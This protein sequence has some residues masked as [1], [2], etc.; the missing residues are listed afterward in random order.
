MK[1]EEYFD[2][3]SKVEI[4]FNGD[5]L[6]LIDYYDKINKICVLNND[7][8]TPIK[9][10]LFYNDVKAGEMEGYLL[11]INYLDEFESLID[12]KEDIYWIL[13]DLWDDL[14]TFFINIYENEYS[15]TKKYFLIEKIKSTVEFKDEGVESFLLNT[16]GLFSEKFLG[17]KIDY[18]ALIYDRA[19]FI[20]N[21]EKYK[22]GVSEGLKYSLLKI[23]KNLNNSRKEVKKEYIRVLAKTYDFLPINTNNKKINIWIKDYEY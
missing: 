12:Y 17:I 13:E 23:I 8:V 9:M 3:I 15:L 11:K 1:F 20:M 21:K 22:M 4:I 5:K 7:I 2:D 14:A 10:E 6:K 16:V 19:K 18:L